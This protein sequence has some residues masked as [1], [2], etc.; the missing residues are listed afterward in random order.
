MIRIVH[1]FGIGLFLVLT[2]SHLLVQPCLSAEKEGAITVTDFR[3]K[4]MTFSKPVTRIVCLI[5]S[6]LSGI[7]MLGAEQQVVGVSSNVYSGPAFSWYAA[8]DGRVRRKELPVPGNWDFVSIEGVIALKPD[9]VILWSSQTDSIAALEELGIKVFGV[10]LTGRED[11]YREMLALGTMTGK[12][13]RARELVAYSRRE[14]DRF[15]RNGPALTPQQQPGVYYMWAQGNLETSCGGSMV[16]D[17][18]SLAG[19]RNVCGGISSEHLV[20]N[21]EQVL[22]WNPDMIVMWFNERKKPLDIIN[23]PQWRTIRAVRNTRVHQLP[24]VFLCDLWT[25]KFQYAVKLLAKWTHPEKFRKLD[26]KE[27]KRS[28]LRMLYGRKLSGV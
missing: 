22:A 8:M 15:S 1:R 27:E 26:L 17:L 5:E 23:D 10:F 28:M 6:A 16:N 7:Y 14:I 13:T 21:M 12:A 4:T 3:G 24:E 25:L 11:V 2:L 18:I 20:V 9:V 19:G